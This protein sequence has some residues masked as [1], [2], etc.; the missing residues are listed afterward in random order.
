MIEILPLKYVPKDEHNE[1]LWIEEECYKYYTKNRKDNCNYLEL[2]DLWLRAPYCED[3]AQSDPFERNNNPD[4]MSEN[5]EEDI[6]W[7]LGEDTFKTIK[8]ELNENSD[9]NILCKRCSCELRPWDNDNIHIVSYHL[10]EHYG[11][12]LETGNKKKPP[13]KLTNQVIKLYGGKCFCCKKSNKKLHIDHIF[14]RSKSGD[15]AFRNL[16]PL[17]EDCGNKKA[18]QLPAEVTV[19]SDI[20]FESYPSDAYEGLFW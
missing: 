1:S 11:I 8:S 10:E 17:C 15:A 12:P 3:C 2:M 20:Y 13:K 9:F 7:S 4:I 14:P 16:Q 18:D 19:F 5:W 6:I